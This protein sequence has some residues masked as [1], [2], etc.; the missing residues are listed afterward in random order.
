MQPL[1]GAD[2]IVETKPVLTLEGPEGDGDI[3]QSLAKQHK[4]KVGNGNIPQSHTAF[5]GFLQKCLPCEP[6]LSV[7]NHS[8]W[9]LSFVKHITSRVRAQGWLARLSG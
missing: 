1:N 2:V 9:C 3:F 4:T 6:H 7:L 5:T 8:L